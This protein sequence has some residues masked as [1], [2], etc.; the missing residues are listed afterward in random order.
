MCGPAPMLLLPEGPSGDLI[1]TRREKNMIRRVLTAV[2]GG[3]AVA[4]ASVAPVH[5]KTELTV[6]TAYENDD[7]RPYKEAFERDNPDIVINWVRDSTGVV[8]A[9]LLAER[10]NPQADAVWGL[11]VTSLLVLDEHDL[12]E[13]YAPAGLDALSAKFRDPRDPPRWIGNS[14]WICALVFNET[15]GRRHG[16]PAPSDWKDLLDPVYRDRI[17]MPHPA[18]SG[19]GFMYV[20]AWLQT[21]GE[22]EGWKFMDAL[23]E[24]IGR[25]THSGSAPA[26]LA[27]QGE[28][29]VGLGFEVRGARVKA[30]G[31]PVEIIM[32]ADALGWD[33]NA[34]AIVRGTR[35]LEAAQR[36]MDWAS[37]TTAVE[38]YGATRS[39]AA[40]P[41]YAKPDPQL[42][43]N[44]DDLIMQQDF[45]WAA[46]NR[47]RILAQ[48]TERY[49]SKA[50]PRN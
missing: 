31:A 24:N 22:E 16:I 40:I 5:A 23:H 32:P 15:E 44:L 19:T 38:M 14:G 48:W 18:S 11:A 2:A 37:S 6:Y 45:A 20:S 39:I 34:M 25:Y 1:S 26:V 43:A 29:L 12:L 42:P 27:G 28:Y 8:T 10:D 41:G 46:R 47:D 33:M 13:P 36:L 49:G 30:Q 3:L 4:L 21:W 17:V 35:K 7:L 9:K 50:E